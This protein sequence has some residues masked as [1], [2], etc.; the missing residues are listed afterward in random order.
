MQLPVFVYGTLLWPEIQRRITGKIFPGQPATLLGYRRGLVRGQTYPSVEPAP[1]SSVPGLLLTGVDG[2]SLERL[3]AYEG[4]DY[5][6]L[7]VQARDEG[8]QQMVPCW[9]WQLRPALRGSITAQPFDLAL[10]VERDLPIFLKNYPGFQAPPE[11]APESP[12]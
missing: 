3:D 9:L 8:S 10:F 5:Q 6:R 2:P 1:D 12:Q 11:T 4:S 7:R